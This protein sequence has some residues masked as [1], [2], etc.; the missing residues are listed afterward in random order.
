MYVCMYV[1]MYVYM[2]VSMCVCMYG[3]VCVF[4]YCVCV[5]INLTVYSMND[6]ITG[7]LPF[8]LHPPAHA[9]PPQETQEEGS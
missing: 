6:L 2:Y 1:C 9:W 7:V 8:S 5:S 3:Y 4:V